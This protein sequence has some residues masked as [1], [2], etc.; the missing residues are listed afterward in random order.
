MRKLFFEAAKL[1]ETGEMSRL[2]RLRQIDKSGNG[3]YVLKRKDKLKVNLP[4]EY[5]L[6]YYSPQRKNNCAVCVCYSF[7][8]FFTTTTYTTRP[9]VCSF[10]QS[11]WTLS[12]VQNQ[13]PTRRFHQDNITIVAIR[14][15]SHATGIQSP[16]ASHKATLPE[17]H[18]YHPSTQES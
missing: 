18:R 10:L 5:F 7:T 13:R 4:L 1:N 11:I 14:L 17:Y 15:L 9:L 2:G 3:G 8:A 12:V 16:T 6:T